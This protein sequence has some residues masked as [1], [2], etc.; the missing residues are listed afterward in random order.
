M[1]RLARAI[2]ARSQIGSKISINLIFLDSGV[3]MSSLEDSMEEID[4]YVQLFPQMGTKTEDSMTCSFLPRN[5]PSYHKNPPG[6]VNWNEA[7]NV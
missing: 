7:T 3:E 5:P 4:K 1:R 6:W 2:E